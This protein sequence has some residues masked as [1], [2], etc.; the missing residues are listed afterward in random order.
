MGL[1]RMKFTKLHLLFLFLGP[2]FAFSSIKMAVTIDDLPTH[3]KLPPGVSRIE[4]A[5]SMLATLKVNK[6]PEVYGFINAGHIGQDKNLTEV[7]NLWIKSG[8]PLGNHTFSHKHLNKTSVEDFY[9]EIAANEPTLKAIGG[10]FD[11]H[12]FRYPFLDEG[13][14]LEKRNSVRTY[15]KANKYKIAFVTDEFED[16]AWNDPYARCKGKNDQK[17]V[18]SLKDSYSS[19]AAERFILDSKILNAIYHRPVARILLLHI[20]AFSAEMLPAIL[21]MYKERDV[22]FIPLS[23]AAKDP[24]YDEDFGIARGGGGDFE[25]NALKA[26][27][28]TIEGLGLG[29]AWKFPGKELSQICAD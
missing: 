8:Y 6:V 2:S 15:L 10:Q 18:R 11:W 22:E 13:G 21:K 3:G 14:S 24:I 17:S 28:L 26:K 16:W 9:N 1:P 4:I 25:Y 29:P 23:E 5:K 27:G 12:Y 19:A 20:G 7:L